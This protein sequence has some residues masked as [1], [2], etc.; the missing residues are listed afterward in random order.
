M[1]ITL[2]TTATGRTSSTVVQQDTTDELVTYPPKELVGSL[3][4]VTVR[5][6]TPSTE[7]P[8]EGAGDAATLSTLDTTVAVAADVGDMSV[9]LTDAT[10]A[11][12]D[13]KV[14]LGPSLQ[15]EFESISGNVVTLKRPLPRALVVGD[16]CKGLD[17]SHALTT[18]ET[19]TTGFGLAI[20]T[21]ETTGKDW[22]QP[23]LISPRV[24]AYDLTAAD[25]RKKYP[26]V[27]R[28]AIDHDADFADALDVA[29]TDEVA[30]DLAERGMDASNIIDWV[31]LNAWHAAAVVY[32]LALNL[33]NIPPEER[34]HWFSRMRAERESA[35]TSSRFW[36]SAA[37]EL[38][39]S[40][41]GPVPGAARLSFRR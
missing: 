40:P 21:D 16:Q 22:P 34:D 32:R 14:L 36:Y 31:H 20:W 6:A 2:A 30:S 11:V 18:S 5:V 25:L 27:D 17:I 10:G 9:T 38:S 29:W 26:I 39:T 37:D 41:S 33:P 24:V 15:V 1:P 13:R 19:E 35:L 7:L 12:A 8:D 4:S 3:T 23:F 28:M